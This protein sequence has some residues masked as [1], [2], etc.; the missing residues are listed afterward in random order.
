MNQPTT[1]SLKLRALKQV[2]FRRDYPTSEAN[3]FLSPQTLNVVQY[4]LAPVK[5]V[6]VEL[7]CHIISLL[8][9]PGSTMSVSS[10]QNLASLLRISSVCRYWRHAAITN[11]LFW[12]DIK[13]KS[14]AE[15]ALRLAITFLKRS[16]GAS[17]AVKIALRNRDPP[18]EL[19]ERF[20]SQL[21]KEGCRLRAFSVDIDYSPKQ[22]GM[23][24]KLRFLA[25]VLES[26]EILYPHP[27]DFG[28]TLDTQTIPLPFDANFP[29]LRAL[30]LGNHI[31]WPAEL[32]VNL[33]TLALKY[34][35]TPDPV[36][37][38][39][40]VTMLQKN[41]SLKS[42]ELARYDLVQPQE[43]ISGF[44]VALDNLESIKLSCC[45]SPLM[46]SV[47]SMPSSCNVEI[48]HEFDF[49]S[50]FGLDESQSTIMSALPQNF[51][52]GH[53]FNA[54]SHL[55]FD[56]HAHPSV[57]FRVHSKNTALLISQ[58]LV[59]W[60]GEIEDCE[61][62][63]HRS[64]DAVS[65]CPD[66]DSTQTLHITN[67]LYADSEDNAPYNF[68]LELWQ[69]WFARLSEL[70]KIETWAIPVP[71]ICYALITQGSSGAFPCKKLQAVHFFLTAANEVE[72]MRTMEALEILVWARG[73]AGIPIQKMT[74]RTSSERH[75]GQDSYPPVDG[76]R[77][78][79]SEYVS[80]LD[81]EED[82]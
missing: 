74:I 61:N 52:A 36:N 80:E 20:L 26:L 51:M 70:E 11:A 31:P 14:Q 13:I 8:A 60:Y 39:A 30:T 2:K 24:D 15:G 62:Y 56:I 59:D 73:E 71:N 50:S 77:Q 4:D 3:S 16:E 10:K 19:L 43:I 37:I 55:E 25:P 29:S 67:D 27:D 42:L 57:D 12:A 64:L 72:A 17:L 78:R 6:P 81:F 44:I 33:T 48:E 34:P 53:Q 18:K 22:V 68:P 54:T 40:F 35:T 45:N 1:N 75:A 5:K 32:I 58:D 41:P 69:R 9:K 46:L 23:L 66:F 28:P 82:V 7:L 79:L 65:R 21:S 63:C 47:I 49:M 38:N 76:W